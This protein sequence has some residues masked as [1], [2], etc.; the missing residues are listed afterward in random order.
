[1]SEQLKNCRSAEIRDMSVTCCYCK[2]K[3]IMNVWYSHFQ[4]SGQ[5]CIIERLFLLKKTHEIQ[6]LCWHA[7]FFVQKTKENHK[8]Q[9]CIWYPHFRQ[10]G[11]SFLCVLRVLT[12]SI[13]AML[14]LNFGTVLTWWCFLLIFI[15]DLLR[16]CNL[17]WMQSTHYMSYRY[18]DYAHFCD[19]TIEFWKVFWFCGFLVYL[20]SRL[21]LLFSTSNA[22]IENQCIFSLC[23][24][25]L[26]L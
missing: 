23:Y 17:L 18:V 24:Q 20:L 14:R 11:W 13:F 10:S 25:L 16:T 12:L 26:L 5:P 3:I 19:V 4:E 21:N 15:I 9:Q 8:M 6:D 2:W 7:D 1:M 22:C